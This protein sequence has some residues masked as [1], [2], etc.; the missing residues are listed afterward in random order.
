[1]FQANREKLRGAMRTLTILIRFFLLFSEAG[2]DIDNRGNKM[3]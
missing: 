1:M 2:G 3:Y